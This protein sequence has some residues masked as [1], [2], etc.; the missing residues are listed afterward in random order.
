M[1]QLIGDTLLN[2]KFRPLLEWKTIVVGLLVLVAVESLLILAYSRYK[3]K[4]T[5]H[6][7]LNQ[8]I[9]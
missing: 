3:I 4:N 6:T 5:S 8:G 9:G 1:G 7:L 2:I